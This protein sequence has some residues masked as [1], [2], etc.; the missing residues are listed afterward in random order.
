MVSYIA[1][2]TI[3]LSKWNGMAALELEGHN[4]NWNGQWHNNK[5]FESEP[6]SPPILCVRVCVCVHVSTCD[7][8]SALMHVCEGG[9]VEAESVSETE[10]QRELICL[11]DGSAKEGWNIVSSSSIKIINRHKTW[12]GYIH[13]H[14]FYHSAYSPYTPTH[15]AWVD[16]QVWSNSSQHV[17][18]SKLWPWILKWSTKDRHIILN[19]KLHIHTQTI[20]HSPSLSFFH[21]QHTHTCAHTHQY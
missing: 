10:R 12:D 6:L 9:D 21:I 7:C 17:K 16:H 19:K 14:H 3:L 18:P 5:E 20:L 1:Y 8:V 13:S 4:F 2:T 11:F 15:C